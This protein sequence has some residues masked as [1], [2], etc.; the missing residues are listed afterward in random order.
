MAVSSQG[1]DPKREKLIFLSKCLSQKSIKFGPQSSS[2]KFELEFLREMSNHRQIVLLMVNSKNALQLSGEISSNFRYQEV[3]FIQ[4]IRSAFGFANENAIFSFTGYDLKYVL[5][6]ILIRA[7]LSRVFVFIYDTH[8]V[9]LRDKHVFKRVVVDLYFQ[10]GFYIATRLNGWV[11]LNSRFVAQRNIK[12][13]IC[14]IKVGANYADYS[15]RHGSTSLPLDILFAGTLNVENGAHI[16]LECIESYSSL[17]VRFHVFGDGPLASQFD[18]LESK[19]M[20]YYGRQPN[21]EVLDTLR[22]CSLAIHLRE[23]SSKVNDYAYPS[24]LIEYIASGSPVI[25]NIF[26]NMG[27]EVEA[28]LLDTIEFSTTAV[29]KSLLETSRNIAVLDEPKDL[30]EFWDQHSWSNIVRCVSNFYSDPAT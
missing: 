21:S 16:I 5:F 8:V 10:A 23:P 4:A 28:V 30:T 13:P 3:T 22:K 9:A 27:S 20:I 2:E 15:P 19:N 24:K 11:V 1:N 12:I 7:F 29:V 25:S 26:P 17:P 6:G 14:R 18:V